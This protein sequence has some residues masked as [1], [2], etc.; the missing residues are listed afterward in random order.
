MWGAACLEDEELETAPSLHP[1]FS[2]SGLQY[3]THRMDQEMD[4][5]EEAELAPM[6]PK[7]YNAPLSEQDLAF[8]SGRSVGRHTGRQDEQGKGL[9]ARPALMAVV[10]WIVAQGTRRVPWWWRRRLPGERRVVLLWWRWGRG[11][12]PTVS[13]RGRAPIDGCC[14]EEEAWPHAQGSLVCSNQVHRGS[15][16]RAIG[17]T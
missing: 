14:Y 9:F 5:D 1:H 11:P 13:G 10:S 4:E 15:S 7:V 8:A 17:D 6:P 16:E 3:E 2:P 12:G